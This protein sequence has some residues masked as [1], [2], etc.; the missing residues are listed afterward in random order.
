MTLRQYEDCLERGTTLIAMATDDGIV[1]AADDL[2]Y[3]QK[4]GE[5]LLRHGTIWAG[6]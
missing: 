3:V 2:V 5:A 1:M 4:G 6:R